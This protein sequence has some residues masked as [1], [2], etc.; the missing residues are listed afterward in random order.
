MLI[1]FSGLD[2][3][4]KSTLINGLKTNLEKRNRQVT[5]LTMYDHVGL[6]PFIR[7]SRD[8]MKTVI[9]GKTAHQGFMKKLSNDPDR[10][11]VYVAKHRWF[12]EGTLA[13]LRS[14][15]VKRLIY[16]FDLCVFLFYCIYFEKL[17]SRILIMDRYFY[18][19][20]ADVADG[21]RWFY[22]RLFLSMIPTP[23]LPIFV[24]VGP[25]EAFARKGEYPVEYME[26][27][28]A[29]YL[30]IFGWVHNPIFIRNDDLGQTVKEIEETVFSYLTPKR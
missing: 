6:Y 3:A 5:V 17:K 29:N 1:T 24:D 20:L 7:F 4:G 25:R 11:G 28:H 14:S 16:I 21:R 10:L 12:M 30:R 13:I 8:W 2:G 9:R 18:D 26:R 23:D 22:I 15:S 27:R 19:S